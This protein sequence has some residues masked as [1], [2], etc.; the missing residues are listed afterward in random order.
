M[1]PPLPVLLLLVLL[2]GVADCVGLPEG[3]PVPLRDVEPLLEALAPA[4]RVVLGV[5]VR[6]GEGEGVAQAVGVPVG[7]PVTE[8]VAEG[9]TV[10]DCVG[11]TAPLML[12]LA[13]AV[14]VAEGLG[15]GDGTAVREAV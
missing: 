15:E 3:V 1:A 11:V 2:L 10:E 9:V 8:E 12:P 5:A 13:E 7:S 14:A 6:V 4:D